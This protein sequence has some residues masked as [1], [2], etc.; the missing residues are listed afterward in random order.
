[1]EKKYK[2]TKIKMRKIKK[3]RVELVEGEGSAVQREVKGG[4]IGELRWQ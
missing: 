1:M 4:Q 3:E 2:Q